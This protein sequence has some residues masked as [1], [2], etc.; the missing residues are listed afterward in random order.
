MDNLFAGIAV[1]GGLIFFSLC[2]LLK[3]NR[4]WKEFMET[5]DFYSQAGCLFVG[6][7]GFLAVVG[8]ILFLVF[9]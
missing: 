4:K 7:L 9:A 3:N 8:L 6:C 5:I 1:V 2:F